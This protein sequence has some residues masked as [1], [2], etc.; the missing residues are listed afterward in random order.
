MTAIWIETSEFPQAP[1]LEAIVACRKIAVQAKLGLEADTSGATL[2]FSAAFEKSLGGQQALLAL[3]RGVRPRL[4]AVVDCHAAA[5]GIE[6][7]LGG[8]LLR[9]SLPS[10]NPFGMIIAADVICADLSQMIAAD[11]ATS[12]LLTLASRVA[13]SD[14][15]VFIN[16]P[17]GTGKEVL[18]R[19]IHDRSDRA[20]APFVAINC[21][22]IPE[23]MLEAVLF[24]HEKGA[25]TGASVA[26]K[27]IFRAADKG[28]LLLD[29]ISE[30]P[31]GLQSKLLR[32]L[33]ERKVTP[34]GAQGEIDVDVRVLATTNR[35][36]RVE[37]QENRFREDLFYRLNVFPMATRALCQRPLDILPI[38]VALLRK[39][40]NGLEALPW[41]SPE[42]CDLLTGHAWP[43]N[44]R[45]L[46]NVIQ[47]ALVLQSGGVITAEDIIIDTA[48]MTQMTPTQEAI[49]PALS[50]LTG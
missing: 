5:F 47:R 4:V 25:F 43:G 30:M 48:P 31:L 40:A 15:T 1:E 45:E 17:T 6:S 13:K 37:V 32:V 46:E 8:K 20:A 16:G 10:D 44:V 34:L 19:Y 11:P 26:N 29:E 12:D 41:L 42:A 50:R 38:A 23:N 49:H 9:I 14:V 39:H 36:M 33:Q 7:A 28:T 2:V 22:A 35:D 21:A 27:G 3:A 18:A 24:G